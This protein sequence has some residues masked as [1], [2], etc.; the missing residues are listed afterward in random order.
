MFDEKELSNVFGTSDE[1]FRSNFDNALATLQASEPRHSAWTRWIGIAFAAC[2]LIAVIGAPWMTGLFGSAPEEAMPMQYMG[3]IIFSKASTPYF[4]GVNNDEVIFGRA[5]VGASWVLVSAPEDYYERSGIELSHCIYSGHEKVTADR[6]PRVNAETAQ[7]LRRLFEGVVFNESG[8]P[9]DF[10]AVAPDSDEFRVDIGSGSLYNASGEELW[11]I[12]YYALGRGEPQ[13]LWI[14]TKAE[15]EARREA[16]RNGDNG[17]KLTDSYDEAA[18]LL[19]DDFR[20]PGVYT[21]GLDA[22]EFKFQSE[23]GR[24]S[25]YV[26]YNG[27]PGIYYFAE[28]VRGGD[29]NPREWYAPGAVIEQLEIEGEMVYKATSKKVI[30]Y[31]WTHDKIAYMIFQGYYPDEFTDEQ[32]IEIIAS[33]IR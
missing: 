15:Y 20:L 23:P 5:D 17:V 29:N 12:H 21:D 11:M 13:E 14:Q 33:M 22:P 16:E 8:E 31:V 28:A 18:S 1:G 25:V 32:F 24:D 6:Q 3:E 9:V 7:A 26:T 27:T 2:M 19:G 30:R 10:I 4:D